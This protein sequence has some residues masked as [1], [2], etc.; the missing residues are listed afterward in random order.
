M[1]DDFFRFFLIIFYL[2]IVFLMDYKK[3]FNPNYH[4]IM[5]IF[6]FIC[7]FCPVLCVQLGGVVQ[8]AGVL[9]KGRV[10]KEG[11]EKIKKKKNKNQKNT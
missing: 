4:F 7:L 1:K 5:T 11:K 9:R 8:A 10:R 6:Y 3:M 2:R